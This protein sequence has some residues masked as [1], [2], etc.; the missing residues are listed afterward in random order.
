MEGLSS[1]DK[2][3]A[4]TEQFQTKKAQYI[5]EIRQQKRDYEITRKRLKF[6]QRI[7]SDE[8]ASVTANYLLY[9]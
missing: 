7:Y 4:S 5:V 8:N 3:E 1:I 9:T 2:T 6:T